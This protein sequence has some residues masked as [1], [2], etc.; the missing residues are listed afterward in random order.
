MDERLI[1]ETS[2]L[3]DL[4][5]EHSAGSAGAAHALLREHSNA[6]LFVT[7][8]VLGEIA[9]GLSEDARPRWQELVGPF[10]VLWCNDEICWRYG[11]LHRILRRSGALIPTNDLWIAATALAHD[12]VV[13]TRDAAHYGRVPDLRVLTY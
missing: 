2:L 1:V 10:P 13:A 12:M 8:T 5:R 9:A 4:E 6:L 11:Q 7:F 3:V